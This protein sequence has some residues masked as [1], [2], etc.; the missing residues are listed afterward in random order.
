[1][2]ATEMKRWATADGVLI[3]FLTRDYKETDKAFKAAD[4]GKEMEVKISPKSR[5]RSISAPSV[6]LSNSKPML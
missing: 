5:K 6:F 3:Q 1:M 4:S 2:N